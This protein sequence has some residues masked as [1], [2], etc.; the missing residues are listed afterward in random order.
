MAMTTKYRHKVVLSV[1]TEDFSMDLSEQDRF[2]EPMR[3]Q[4][5]LNAFLRRVHEASDD[6]VKIE[7]YAAESSARVW[8]G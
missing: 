7:S 4:D 1:M 5:Q 6:R 2:E 8:V 3:H